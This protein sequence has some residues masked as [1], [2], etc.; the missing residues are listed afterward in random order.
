MEKKRGESSE[1]RASDAAEMA[2]HDGRPA[3]GRPADERAARGPATG[4][5]FSNEHDPGGR[6]NEGDRPNRCHD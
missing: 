5:S 6:R 2:E 3:K 1:R 4:E